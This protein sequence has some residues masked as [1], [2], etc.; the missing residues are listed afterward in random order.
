M[1][2]SPA[3]RILFSEN[4]NEGLVCRTGQPVNELYDCSLLSFVEHIIRKRKFVAKEN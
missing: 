3:E 2:N 1:S 4:E